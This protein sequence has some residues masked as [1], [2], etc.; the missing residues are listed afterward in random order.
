MHVVIIR[1]T[2]NSCHSLGGH[3]FNTILGST[4]VKSRWVDLVQYESY[5]HLIGY[6]QYISRHYVSL[7]VELPTKLVVQMASPSTTLATPPSS[8]CTVP[9][10]ATHAPASSCKDPSVRLDDWVLFFQWVSTWNGWTEEEE[11]IQLAGNL[12]GR[13]LQE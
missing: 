3:E 6:I 1:Y 4:V 10:S 12:R 9:A 11:V 5:I 8:G 7:C 2:M 13:A